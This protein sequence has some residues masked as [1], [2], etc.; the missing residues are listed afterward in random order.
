MQK[1]LWHSAKAPLQLKKG[2]TVG[3]NV[4]ISLECILTK[5]ELSMPSRFQN[6]A[7]QN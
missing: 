1:Y 7:V 3:Q 5:F 2:I 6:T 4:R